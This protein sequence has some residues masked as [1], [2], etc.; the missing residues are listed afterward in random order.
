M[1]ES[2]PR[3]AIGPWANIARDLANLGAFACIVFVLF[4]LPG[5]VGAI[6]HGRH[7]A[8]Q[9][10]CGSQVRMI[11]AGFVAWAQHD[12]RR[13]PDSIDPLDSGSEP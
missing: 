10:K 8:R 13:A 2:Q 12:D 11:Q 7:T 4:I 1:S 6:K 5:L 3:R 9:V